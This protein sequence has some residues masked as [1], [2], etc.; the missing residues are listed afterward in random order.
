MSTERK[1]QGYAL[2]VLATAVA[3]GVRALLGLV[4]APPPFIS[5]YPAILIAGWWWGR[6]PAL[7]C[8]GLSALISGHL[9]VLPNRLAGPESSGVLDLS[10]YVL[11]GAILAFMSAGFREARDRAESSRQRLVRLFE[12]TGDAFMAF[13]AGWRYVHVNRHAARFARLKPEQMIGHT[14]FELFPDIR[15]SGPFFEAAEKVMKERVP[16]SVESY[17]PRLD[18][19]FQ[20][21]IYPIEDDGIG[22]FYRDVT[23]RRRAAEVREELLR[24]EQAARTESET[25]NRLK[26]EFLAT[27]SHELRTPL[28][29]I[30]G[31]ATLLAQRC[32]NPA[33]TAAAIETIQR[34][35]RAQAH[36]VEDL[37][38]VSR[39]ISG[40]LRL[41]IQAVELGTLLEA[42]LAAVRPAADARGV[43]L[44]VAIDSRAAVVNGDPARLQQIAWNLLSNAIK[45]TPKGGRVELVLRR[46]NSHVELTVSDTGIGIPSHMLQRIFDRFAQADSSSTREYHGLGL[47]LALV[48]H[49]TEAHGGTVTA[50]SPGEGRGA[51]FTV[52]LPLRV[53]QQDAWPERR[54]EGTEAAREAPVEGDSLRGVSVLIAEDNSEARELLSKML[55]AMGASVTVTSSASEAM[56]EIDR[57]IPDVLL[58]D[59]E[60]PGEDGYSLIRRVR[61]RTDAASQLPAIA[62][63]GYAR[64]QDRTRAI[65]E[66]FDNHVAKPVYVP[67]LAAVISR[68]VAAKRPTPS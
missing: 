52:S 48:R 59:I 32:L 2:A 6:G 30:T 35:A 14:I 43:R 56:V 4:G 21:D 61:G 29:A 7:L 46:A 15:T 25:A 33:E 57:R 10:L 47:G 24:R 27:L 41:D 28:N 9:W 63:T 12:S 11:V 40:K 5:F 64:V 22:V 68:A 44:Q 13:D 23:E 17:Y 62:I 3:I 51:T 1:A 50:Y 31:W 60:M 26:D 54:T 37:L 45:F 53:A 8:V 19:W 58:S 36:L 55:S 67:E 18:M 20:N 38:D 39:I 49:L 16:I 66:G 42:A 34:N 65:R